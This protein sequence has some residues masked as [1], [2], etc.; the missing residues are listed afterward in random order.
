MATPT[1]ESTRTERQAL[2][3]A[4]E[5]AERTATDEG[6]CIRTVPLRRTGITNGAAGIVDVP[7]GS[8]RESRSPSYAKR[9]HSIRRSQREEG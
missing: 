1:G 4:R 7:C 6:V 5:A 9:E 8:T 2:P 3:L